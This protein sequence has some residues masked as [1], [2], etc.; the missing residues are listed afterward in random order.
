MSVRDPKATLRQIR[1][2]ARHAREIC[3]NKTLEGL[4]QD[5]Q[6]TAAL[7]RA[8]AGQPSLAEI[9]SSKLRTVLRQSNISRSRTIERSA[10][11]ST[12]VGA[13]GNVGAAQ[14]STAE[15]GQTQRNENLCDDLPLR[16][17]R[18]TR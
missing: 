18:T 11:P 13:R 9:K 4:L 12:P 15:T 2:A 7:E 10:P 3:S 16:C 1:D 6:A 17:K 8:A 5:W 14:Q